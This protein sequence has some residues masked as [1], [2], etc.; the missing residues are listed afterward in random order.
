MIKV[1]P[2]G[3][4]LRSG[5]LTGTMADEGNVMRLLL[6]MMTYLEGKQKSS[7]LFATVYGSWGQMT[8]LFGPV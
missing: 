1:V 7:S 8:S 3:G 2:R 6:E 5:H 4:D